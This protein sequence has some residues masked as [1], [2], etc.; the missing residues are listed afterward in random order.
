[1]LNPNNSQN[2]A[3][4]FDL[5]SKLSYNLSLS[6]DC[7]KL[8]SNNKAKRFICEKPNLAETCQTCPFLSMC[9]GGCKRMKDAMYVDQDGDCGYAALLH[10]FLPQIDHILSTVE[11]R[12]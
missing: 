1:M 2:S 5:M 6:S 9:R 3:Y 12:S 7:N 10:D 11:E 4:K 8:F